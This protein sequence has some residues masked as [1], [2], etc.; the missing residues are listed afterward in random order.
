MLVATEIDQDGEGEELLALQPVRQPAEEEGAAHGADQ[1]GGGGK[2]HPRLAQA[3][4]LVDGAREAADKRDLQPVEVPG[5]AE[6]HDYESVKA[7]PGKTV[8]AVRDLRFEGGGLRHG[9]PGRSS[10]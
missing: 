7:A 8:E 10:A 3:R 6:D 4:A 1:V 2:A 9:A 5:N